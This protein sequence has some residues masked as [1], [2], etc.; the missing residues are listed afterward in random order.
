MYRVPS[1]CGALPHGVAKS[2]QPYRSLAF[3]V[4]RLLDGVEDAGVAGAAA[5]V[6]GKPLLDLRQRGI[7][8]SLEQVVGGEDHTRGADAAL[9]SAALEEA[10]LEGM[11]LF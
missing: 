4:C 6:A 3:A 2:P 5:E 10:L 9:G 7:G 1:C 11:K 8:V